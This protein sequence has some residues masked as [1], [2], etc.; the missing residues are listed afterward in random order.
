MAIVKN[1]GWHLLWY[2][3]LAIAIFFLVF[4]FDLV[5]GFRYT[6]ILLSHWTWMLLLSPSAAAWFG[7]TLVSIFMPVQVIF[8]IPTLFDP[9]EGNRD[10]AHWSAL[11]VV[12]VMLLWV[13]G[14]WV[15]IW[16]SFPLDN[17]TDG[18]HMRMIPF[19]PWPSQSFWPK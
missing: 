19:V 11:A 18:I 3:P 13:F 8:Q 17:A 4:L 10:V 16:G 7:A 6:G 15:V 5:Q 14:S 1:M 9:Y 2:L 12:L